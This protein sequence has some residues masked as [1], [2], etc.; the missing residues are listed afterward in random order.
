MLIPNDHHTYGAVNYRGRTSSIK[1]DRYTEA[2]A[3]RYLMNRMR[4]I[5]SELVIVRNKAHKADPSYRPAWKSYHHHLVS[6]LSLY[7]RSQ[8]LKNGSRH[9]NKHKAAA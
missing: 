3:V 2:D 9:G 1:L 4:G 7:S 6:E 8:K 5:Q